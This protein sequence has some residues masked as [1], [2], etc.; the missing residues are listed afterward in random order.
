MEMKI[1]KLF[2]WGRGDG[3]TK[4]KIRRE[5]KTNMTAHSPMFMMAF[6]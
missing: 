5:K 4:K 1:I 3:G 6:C 2:I